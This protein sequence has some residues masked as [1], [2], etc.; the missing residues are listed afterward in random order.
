MACKYFQRKSHN[1]NIHAKF[2]VTDQLTN[3]FKSKETLTQQLIKRQ[4]VW[5]LKLDMIRLEVLTWDLVKSKHNNYNKRL[6]SRIRFVCT[7]CSCHVTYAFES[8][9]TL[10]SCLNVKEL[11]A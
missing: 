3:T 9:S 10:Y 11:L 2:T 5:I 6:L 4:N 1:F 8:E 7:V